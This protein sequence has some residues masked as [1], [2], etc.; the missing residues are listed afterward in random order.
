MVPIVLLLFES[1][2][3]VLSPLVSDWL[4]R[5]S[6]FYLF[7]YLVFLFYSIFLFFGFWC[8]LFRWFYNFVVPKLF[9]SNFLIVVLTSFVFLFILM[10][11]NIRLI[12]L[13][14]FFMHYTGLRLVILSLCQVSCFSF[15]HNHWPSN[16][17]L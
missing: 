8:S 10:F 11:Y 13:D 1:Q 16:S 6:C 2:R 12:R 14:I 4:Y 17:L 7:I 3:C 15:M 9:S 5:V